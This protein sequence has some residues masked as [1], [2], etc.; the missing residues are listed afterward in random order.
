M[1]LST[2]AHLNSEKNISSVVFKL[3]LILMLKAGKK[4]KVLLSSLVQ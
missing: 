1:A 3:P 4:T 2:T